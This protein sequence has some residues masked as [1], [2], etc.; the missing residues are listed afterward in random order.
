MADTGSF[1]EA[2]PCVGDG[3]RCQRRQRAWQRHESCTRAFLDGVVDDVE[4]QNACVEPLALA[5]RQRSED[6]RIV[7][8]EYEPRLGRRAIDRQSQIFAL[9]QEDPPRTQTRECFASSPV[10]LAAVDEYRI[11]A[12]RDVVQKETIADTAHVDTPFRSCERGE[13]ADRIAAV[14]AEI[15]REVIPRPE[16]DA[17]KWEVAFDR[18]RR[19]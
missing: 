12:E 6:V 17:D 14:D 9:R 18:D 3:K 8:D 5:E 4:M 16:R 19:D 1:T 10:S 15:P 13:R 2:A 11:D 7:C